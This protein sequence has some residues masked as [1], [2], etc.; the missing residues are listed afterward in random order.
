[1]HNFPWPKR[2]TDNVSAA[3]WKKL[4]QRSGSLAEKLIALLFVEK[5][6]ELF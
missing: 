1:M 3:D 6:P 5:F 2:D 4:T